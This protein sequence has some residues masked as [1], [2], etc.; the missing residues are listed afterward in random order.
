MAQ[1]KMTQS[2]F[3]VSLVSSRADLFR[4]GQRRFIF[5]VRSRMQ[6]QRYE[7]HAFNYEEA[8][9]G[10]NEAVV[11]SLTNAGDTFEPKPGR[12]YSENG[13]Q[14][15]SGGT[16]AVIVIGTLVAQWTAGLILSWL[17]YRAMTPDE[18]IRYDMARATKV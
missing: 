3:K 5:D 17:A 11:T 9:A 6:V 10:L 1:G 12:Y 7:V 4:P 15:V 2:P 8:L 13:S 14:S 16:V 18:R